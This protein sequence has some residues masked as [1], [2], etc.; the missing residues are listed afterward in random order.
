MQLLIY[1]EITPDN[2]HKTPVGG[3]FEASLAAEILWDRMIEKQSRSQWGQACIALSPQIVQSP[4]FPRCIKPAIY[5]P[6]R[7]DLSDSEY[8]LIHN[9]RFMT[10]ITSDVFLEIVRS[11]DADIIA[12]CAT[13]RLKAF[14]ETPCIVEGLGLVGVSRPYADGVEPVS[15]M[16]DWPHHLLVRKNKTPFSDPLWNEQPFQQWLN[17]TPCNQKPPFFLEVGGTV[18]DFNSQAGF[19]SLL[20]ELPDEAITQHCQTSLASSVQV[21]GDVICGHQVQVAPEAVLVSPVVICEQA[22]IGRGAVIENCIIGSGVT[23]PAE[24]LLK[25]RVVWT[26]SDIDAPQPAEYH[27]AMGSAQPISFRQWPWWSYVHQGK[28]IIDIL[29]SLAVLIICL[30]IFVIVFGVIKITSPGPVFYRA[31]RQGR[32]G[33]EFDCLKFRSM[34]LRADALQDRLRVVNQVD[35]PQFKIGD[36]PRITGVGKF[37]RDT[38]IDEIPQFI[39]VLLGQMSVIG[40]R[41][42]PEEENRNCPP[43]RDARLSVRPGITGLWQVSRTRKAG[44]DFQEWVHY[45]T[46]YVR[47]VSVWLDVKICVR[48]IMHLFKQFFAQFG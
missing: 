25:N 42:S 37:L 47:N 2:R 4:R 3:L 45:D 22:V 48:T 8:L 27:P 11:V 24:T 30:P 28:R 34:I 9:A 26:Q 13:P 20:N 29:F 10:D 41:P 19:L 32:Y 43:W 14:S 5:D 6:Q 33:E 44:M 1:P 12:I 16:T 18:L 23:V 31:R 36:D 39:N 35:G 40:P 21:F 7:T 46:E 17:S 15:E 38:C